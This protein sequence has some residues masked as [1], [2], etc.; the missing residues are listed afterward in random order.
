MSAN[1]SVTR[2]LFIFCILECEFEGKCTVCQ[3]VEFPG[4]KYPT[5]FRSFRFF[6]HFNCGPS[7]SPLVTPASAL[8]SRALLEMSAR[9]ARD[10]YM[11]FV[12]RYI[13][14][15]KRFK[16][17]SMA[18]PSYIPFAFLVAQY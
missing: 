17:S 13:A 4:N 1:N 14:Q 15:V 3:G 12:E 8:D 7:V 16:S 18:P 10:S 2:D 9:P 11:C 5:A 6:V